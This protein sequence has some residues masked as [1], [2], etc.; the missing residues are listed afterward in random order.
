[1]ASAGDHNERLIISHHSAVDTFRDTVPV[2]VTFPEI[3]IA[4]IN[5]PLNRDTHNAEDRA[6]IFDE[7]NID[8]ELTPLA[9]ISQK[10]YCRYRLFSDRP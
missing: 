3:Q 2:A 9:L 1:M 10:P 4:G 7:G 6:M 5:Q 8:R